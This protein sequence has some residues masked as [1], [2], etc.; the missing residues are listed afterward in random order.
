MNGET[1]T[2]NNR[3]RLDGRVAIVTGSG[4]PAGIGCV[5]AQILASAG[6]KVVLADLESADLD[7]ATAAVKEYGPAVSKSVD[8]SDEASVQELVEFTVD[9]YGRIDV[10][11]N[12]AAAVNP[13]VHLDG[14]VTNL[15][16]ELW[17]RLFA[18]NARGT[19]LMCKHVIPKMLHAGGG[20]IINISS[21]SW[22]H[23]DDFPTAYACS[24]GAVVTLTKYV[25]AQF[26][27]QGIRC[28]S[29]SP[30][31][32]RSAK[33]E[34]ELI[35]PIQEA[36]RVQTMLG[37]LGLASDIGHA[38]AFLAS[39]AASFITGQVINVDGGM[40]AHQP[41]S[42]GIRQVFEQLKETAGS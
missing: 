25:A 38:V 3:T 41:Q 15:S 27:L 20:S 28:N 16:T 26:G 10:L 35:E 22:S 18:V 40:L 2:Y 8:I 7:A 4:D 13:H 42:H 17:D 24:K 23:G 29:I 19:M 9:T 34:A 32:M 21:D 14:A 39:D 12:N 5:T 36:F 1:M 30:G 31:L 11:D 33:M 6:A 37:R